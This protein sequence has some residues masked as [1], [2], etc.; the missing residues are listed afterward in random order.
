MVRFFSGGGTPGK[1]A[2]ATMLPTP[3]S[4]APTHAPAPLRLPRG[5]APLCA[6]GGL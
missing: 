6:G 3:I 2:P 4:L 1:G 5:G